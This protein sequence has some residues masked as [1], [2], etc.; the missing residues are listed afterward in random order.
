[1]EQPHCITHKWIRFKESGIHGWGGF[2]RTDIPAETDVI[3]YVGEKINKRESARRCE[4]NNSFIFA[5]D[6]EFDLDGGVAWNPARLLNHS[7][8]PNC[9]AVWIDG[10]I[11]I[12]ANRLIRAGEEITYDYGYDLEDYASY[13]CH[14]GGPNCVGYMVAAELARLVRKRS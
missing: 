1:M 3:E 12:V 10:H 9:D 2:A 4:S 8:S 5:V 7:C 13:P 14:C 11:W 6:E